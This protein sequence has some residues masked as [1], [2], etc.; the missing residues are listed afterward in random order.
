MLTPS[1]LDH[2]LGTAGSVSF[3]SRSWASRRWEAFQLSDAIKQVCKVGREEGG[4]I[5]RE[6][7]IVNL[8]S[9]PSVPLV[10]IL[11]CVQ[12]VR[13]VFIGRGGGGG[14]GLVRAVCTRNAAG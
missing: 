7:A 3:P 13:Q 9:A 11:L 6:M 1:W 2:P 8:V 5:W 4:I 12:H 10:T 14:S